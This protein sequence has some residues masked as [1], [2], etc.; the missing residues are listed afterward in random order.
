MYLDLHA[1]TSKKSCFI[2]GNNTSSEA[3]LIKTMLF[4]KLISQNC[5]NFE[6][7]ECSFAQSLDNTPD[8][9]GLT[10]DGSGRSVAQKVTGLPYCYTLECNYATGVR[11]N[12][13]GLR[14][15]VAKGE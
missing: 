13:L 10:R 7:S 3:E 4:P 15:D 11:S 14:F 6:F 12:K 9:D 8:A 2:Y 1:H 5:I